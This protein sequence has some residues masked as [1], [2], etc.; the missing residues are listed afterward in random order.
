[1]H[2]TTGIAMLTR[3]Y[4]TTR[5]WRYEYQRKAWV[6]S[7]HSCFV[8]RLRCNICSSYV[9][10]TWTSSSVTPILMSTFV[11]SW[12]LTTLTLHMMK[13]VCDLPNWL[14]VKYSKL[15]LLKLNASVNNGW[16]VRFDFT[17]VKFKQVDS[18]YSVSVVPW[19]TFGGC[20]AHH[21]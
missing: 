15:R 4:Q 1:M 10:L 16:S 14:K 11:I 7:S 9:T 8:D 12:R 5:I 13:I 18:R 2:L 21:D 17:I 19:Y 20:H 6:R 3:W